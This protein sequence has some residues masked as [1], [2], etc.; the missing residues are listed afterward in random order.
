MCLNQESADLDVG[1]SREIRQIL[2][3]AWSDDPVERP[4]IDEIYQRLSTS[5]SECRYIRVTTNQK[6][7]SRSVS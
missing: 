6:D 4:P 3:E 1:C 5:I 7:A 2:E